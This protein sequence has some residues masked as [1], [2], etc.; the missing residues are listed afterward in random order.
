MTRRRRDA[1]DRASKTEAAAHRIVAWIRR[2]GYAFVLIGLL[3][4]L[5]PLVVV[6][7]LEQRFDEAPGVKFLGL[8]C[9]LLGGVGVGV[10]HTIE[11][12]TQH[13][14]P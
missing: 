1:I 7:L 4:I 8:A 11:S 5:L 13:R 9:L 14:R 2:I 3:A 10:A 6:V 12:L